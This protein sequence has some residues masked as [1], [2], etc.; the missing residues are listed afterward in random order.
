MMKHFREK[1]EGMDVDAL[2]NL[3]KRQ[4]AEID[5]LKRDLTEME[6]VWKTKMLGFYLSKGERG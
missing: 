1:L 6:D 5:I 3:M 4:Q 2:Q